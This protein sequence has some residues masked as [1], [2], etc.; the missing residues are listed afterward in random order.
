MY[1]DTNVIMY[2]HD[3]YLQ[4]KISNHFQNCS[5]KLLRSRSDKKRFLDNV[6]MDMQQ[7]IKS[8]TF[9]NETTDQRVNGDVHIR[10][11]MM[12]FSAHVAW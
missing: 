3:T 6:V 1:P 5:L 2:V 8:N 9:A 10:S 12:V 7:C 4:V 11:V